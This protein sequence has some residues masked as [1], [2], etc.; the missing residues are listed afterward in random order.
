M[1]T[2]VSAPQWRSRVVAADTIARLALRQ[3][4]GYVAATR[5]LH[6]GLFERGPDAAGVPQ[7]PDGAVLVV[8]VERGGRR[9]GVAALAD[10]SG[11]VFGDDEVTRAERI[12]RTIAHGIAKRRTDQA[13][14]VVACLLHELGGE[15]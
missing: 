10:R 7:S 11:R 4:G 13:P 3:S 8:T 1:P 2:S 12:T 9:V 15:T 5:V 6:D 14:A